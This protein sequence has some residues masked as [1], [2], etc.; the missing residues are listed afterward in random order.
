MTP[1]N[2]YNPV[3][4]AKAQERYCDDSE[5]PMFAPHDGICY[6]CG[7]NIYLPSNGR[8][9]AVLGITGEDAGKKLVTG[10]PHCNYSFVE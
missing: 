6:H 2:N 4:A 3:L 7:R 10:C 8:R 1:D 9:G 5:R